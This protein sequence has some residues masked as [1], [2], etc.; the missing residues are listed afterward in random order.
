V[1]VVAV[2]SI[3]KFTRFTSEEVKSITQEVLKQHC[4]KSVDRAHPDMPLTYATK[5]E[6]RLSVVRVESRLGQIEVKLDRVINRS[7]RRRDR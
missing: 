2:V 4:D 7:H 6:L 3:V 5:H 1:M